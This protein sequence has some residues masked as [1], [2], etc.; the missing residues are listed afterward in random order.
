MATIKLIIRRNKGSV[1]Q[2]GSTLILLRYTHK[3]QTKY[4]STGLSVFPK[5]WDARNQRIKKSNRGFTTKNMVLTKFKQ[6]FDDIVHKAIYDEIEPTGSFVR[7]EYEIEQNKAEGKQGKQGKSIHHLTW[8]HFKNDFV[9]ES[10]RTKK[11]STIRS[12]NDFIHLLDLFKK[13]RGIKELIWQSFTLDFYYDFMK[14]HIEERGA[15]NNT[16][17]KMIKTLK[18]FL[19]AATER[20]FNKCLDFRSKRFKVFQ[21]EVSHIYL[22]EDEIQCLLDLKLENDTKLREIRDLF[23]IACYTGVRFGDF[24]QINEQNIRDGRLRIKTHKT[25]QYVVIPFHPIVK[26]II[27]NYAGKLPNSYCNMIVNRELKIIGKMAGFS[28]TIIKSRMH[29]VRRVEQT[30]EKWELLSTHCARRSFATNLYKQGFPTVSIMKI[31]G[32]RSEK[33]FM[34]YIKVTEDEVANMLE[35]HWNSFQMTG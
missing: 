13:S 21:E 35:E 4:F 29:G 28:K 17:G 24:K 5:D 31:T 10:R 1:N 12:Y 22:N 16:F 20:G 32:H 7:A 11:P 9:D 15:S 19:N 8:E 14:F 25:G 18:T 26:N 34:R 3:G 27:A 6:K 30:F 23:V 33:T 2:D